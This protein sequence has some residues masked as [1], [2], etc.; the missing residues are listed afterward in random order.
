MKNNTQ[1]PF[2][3]RISIFLLFAALSIYSSAAIGQTAQSGEQA[4]PGPGDR[5]KA[6]ILL[7]IAHPDDEQGVTGYLARAMDDH[8]RVAVLW[9]T[10]GDTGG[11]QVGWAK[12]S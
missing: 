11:D 3:S 4:N 12:E 10:R 1:I 5:F 2:V 7:I 8:K 6:D 9:P